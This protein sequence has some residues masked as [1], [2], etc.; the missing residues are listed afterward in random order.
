M[1]MA[2][3]GQIGPC[4]ESEMGSGVLVSGQQPILGGRDPCQLGVQPGFLACAGSGLLSAGGRELGS[5]HL[6]RASNAAPGPRDDWARLPDDDAED[7]G[8]SNPERLEVLYRQL[9]TVFE[10]T[11]MSPEQQIFITA[12]WRCADTLHV[13]EASAGYLTG[14]GF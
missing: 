2:S 8:T 6:W 5:E 3:S 9:R 10:G 13:A 12:R 4:A 11:A 14:T 1:I 7:I